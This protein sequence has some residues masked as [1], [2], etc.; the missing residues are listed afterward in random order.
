MNIY[1]NGDSHSCAA[2]AVNNYTWACDDPR[3]HELGHRGHPDNLA[4]SYGSLLGRFLS[5]DVVNH[6]EAASSNE[7]IMRSTREYLKNNRP[8]LLVIGW[9]TWEREEW[10]HDGV[11]Y[12]VTASGTDDVPEELNQR[13][14]EWAVYQADHWREAELHAFQSVVDFHYELE[15]TK[16]PHIFFNTFTCFEHIPVSDRVDFRDSYISPY[17]LEK[18]YWHYLNKCGYKTISES[19]YHY[20][21]DGQAAW[22]VVLLEYINDYLRKR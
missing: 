8:D 22:S 4:V 6:A 5:A 18:S 15:A 12:Q 20:G 7:R 16:Q 14:K 11:Y 19:N 21:I 2:E 3:Y 1:I 17:C 9:A 10:L 13:Y